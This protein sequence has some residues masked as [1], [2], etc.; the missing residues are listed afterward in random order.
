[1]NS[2]NI[3]YE[4][5]KELIKDIFVRKFSDDQ[6]RELFDKADVDRKGIISRAKF[7][8]FV[9]YLE[10]SSKQHHEQYRVR[11]KQQ[12]PSNTTSNPK[13]LKSLESI[14]VSL[15]TEDEKVVSVERP[16]HWRLLYCGGSAPVVADLKKVSAE[17]AI[18]LSMESFA[19]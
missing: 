16:D 1:M 3:S 10:E 19:W 12:D 17:H 13:V 6:L 18:P 15:P 2:R 4:G 14:T 5:L 7:D 8:Q 9:K 11:K